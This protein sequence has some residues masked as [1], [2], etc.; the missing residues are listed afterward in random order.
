[1]RFSVKQLVW[2]LGALLLCSGFFA[3]IHS[4]EDSKLRQSKIASPQPIV[5]AAEERQLRAK[6]ADGKKALKE[7]DE[8]KASVSDSSSRVESSP[9]VLK[10]VPGRQR[11]FLSREA[12]RAIAKQMQ[13]VDKG[14]RR[15]TL[16]LLSTLSAE[17]VQAEP[18]L[19]DALED[20]RQQGLDPATELRKL[21]KQKTS[22]PSVQTP[23]RGQEEEAD[24]TFFL[25][26]THGIAGEFA[27]TT[28]RL[29]L[30][31]FPGPTNFAAVFMFDVGLEIESIEALSVLQATK[32]TIKFTNQAA[33]RA[34]L[35]VSGNREALSPGLLC[36]I[37]FRVKSHTPQRSVISLTNVG[38]FGQANPDV[39]AQG[40][41]LILRKRP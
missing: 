40:A 14:S 41:T 32:K 11:F 8:K 6:E 12:G 23:R 30:G 35:E 13:Q 39:F 10:S 36:R 24:L 9:Q 25:T 3:L 5:K 38:I 16:F 26:E 15:H 34:L 4:H 7:A 1:M 37:R 20:L 18:L 19:R 22:E 28:L 2:F 21:E 33:G 17:Q 31:R 27:E 29:S